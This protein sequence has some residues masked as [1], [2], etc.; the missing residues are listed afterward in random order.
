MSECAICLVL[1]YV[2]CI[3]TLRINCK[4]YGPLS[5]HEMLDRDS[6]FNFN[7]T[8]VS[9]ADVGVPSGGRRK[10]GHADRDGKLSEEEQSG[11]RQDASCQPSSAGHQ[12]VIAGDYPA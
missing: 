4:V 2:L 12:Y 6:N 8:D 11:D 10:R 9:V 7:N 1:F 5:L 3:M